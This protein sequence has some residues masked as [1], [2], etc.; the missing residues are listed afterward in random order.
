MAV[1]VERNYANL[2]MHLLADVGDVRENGLFVSFSVNGGRGDSV[3][4]LGRIREQRRI[5]SV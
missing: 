2:T 5:R 3:T 4:F 1:T